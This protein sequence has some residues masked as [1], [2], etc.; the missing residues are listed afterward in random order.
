MATLLT[1]TYLFATSTGV[2]P[3]RKR[4]AKSYAGLPIVLVNCMKIYNFSIFIFSIFVNLKNNQFGTFRNTQSI[5]KLRRT[6]T[7]NLCTLSIMT[8]TFKAFASR[9][10]CKYTLINMI[11]KQNLRLLISYS[12]SFWTSKTTFVWTPSKIVQMS[13]S[14]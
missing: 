4:W 9:N 14:V 8:S 1:W 13:K 11:P 7:A 6:R 2:R 10:A 12:V 3:R 5:Q